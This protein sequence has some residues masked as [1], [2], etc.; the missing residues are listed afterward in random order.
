M[1]GLETKKGDDGKITYLTIPAA[2]EPI[3]FTEK[4]ESI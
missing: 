2:I 4:I 1:M 3:H